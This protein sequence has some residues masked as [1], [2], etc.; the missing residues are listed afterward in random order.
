MPSLRDLAGFAGRFAMGAVGGEPYLDQMNRNR[1][2][3][4]QQQEQRRIQDERDREFALRQQEFTGQA[5][6]RRLADM[7]NQF[8]LEQAQREPA[9]TEAAQAAYMRFRG[10]DPAVGLFEG[11]TP[12]AGAMFSKQLDAKQA[13]Q[14]QA[15]K[16]AMSMRPKPEAGFTLGSGEVRYDNKGNVV[17]RG[18]AKTPSAQSPLGKLAQDLQSGVITRAQFDEGVARLRGGAGG[19]RT[20]PDANR[21]ADIS[22][23]IRIYDT[24][25]PRTMFGERVPGAPPFEEFQRNEL[26][27]YLQALEERGVST[28]TP[29]ATV[30]PAPAEMVPS[31]EIRNGKLVPVGR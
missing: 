26:P 6:S 8:R 21:R 27:Q 13:Q 9:D 15:A 22:T 24:V 4:M 31:F 30:P 19:G 7:A 12:G 20:N 17:G 3:E 25:Y 1:Q 11:M 2:F 28:P 18:P 16:D 10:G 5:E 23:A 14:M 29:T